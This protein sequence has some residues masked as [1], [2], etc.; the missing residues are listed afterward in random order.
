MREARGGGERE[1]RSVVGLRRK[2]IRGWTVAG[3]L[4]VESKKELGGRKEV[5]RNT[6]I[7]SS[8]SSSGAVCATLGEGATKPPPVSKVL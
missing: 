1:E 6:K 8:T 2:K 7:C 4:E 3:F 5:K